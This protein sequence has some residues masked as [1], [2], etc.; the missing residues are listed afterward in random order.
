MCCGFPPHLPGP[1]VKRDDETVRRGVVDHVLKYCEVLGSCGTGRDGKVPHVAGH[2]A[3]I[4]PQLVSIRRVE[5]K[6]SGSGQDRIEYAFID[7]RDGFLR[8][9]GQAARPDQPK[10]VNVFLVD[11]IERTEALRVIGPAKHQPIIRARVLEHLLRHGRK[12]FLL[13]GHN[14][15]RKRNGNRC[16]S[17]QNPKH[18]EVMYPDHKYFLCCLRVARAISTRPEIR[19]PAHAVLQYRLD[20]SKADHRP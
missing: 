18:G 13:R 3:Q 20:G 14:I 2:I 8:S 1:C 10:L 11:L 5:R 15:S 9:L 12:V 16:N 19:L 17:S 6:H 4:F 7:K